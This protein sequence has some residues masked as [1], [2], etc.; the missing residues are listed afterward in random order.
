HGLDDPPVAGIHAIPYTLV[1]ADREAGA[2][3]V[4][5]GIV[6][7]AGRLVQTDRHVEPGPDPFAGVDRAGLERRHDL[8]ARQSHHCGA[9]PP[10]DLGAKPAH[11]VA[12]PFV[13]LRRVDLA[14]EP[15]AHLATGARAEKRLDIELSAELVPQRLTAAVLDPREQFVCGESEWDGPEEMQRL[16]FLLE[17]AFE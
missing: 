15:P 10:E 8:A 14:D 2:G 1:G 6:V 13:V 9:Q 11:S 4:K 5:C 7:K 3:L 17:V 12:Q 16:R